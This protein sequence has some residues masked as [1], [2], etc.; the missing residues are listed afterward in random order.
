M[1]QTIFSA[2]TTDTAISLGSTLLT[3][4]I[5]F[6]LGVAIS[7]TYMKTG[8]KNTYSQ[9]FSITLVLVPT[10]IAI[11]ILMIGS[12][13][14]R[15][16]SLAGAFSIIRFRS[17]PG[18]PKDISYVLFAL[19][20]GLS[21]GVGFYQYAMLF[22]GVLCLLMFALSAFN[23]GAKNSCRKL[24]KI[25]IPEDMN[26]EGAFDDILKNFTTDYTLAKVK[27]TGLGS[28]YELVYNITMN[29]EMSQKEFLDA[30]RCRNGNLN[31]TLSMCADSAE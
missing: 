22:T 7:L 12:N 31:I 20:A 9:S 21:C 16:F 25:T 11:I 10:L 19:A 18:D 13:V 29:K 23:F 5:S 26:Y 4:A 17:S 27:T 1:F 14:A 3:I 6:I 15:A 28:L 2:A 8:S 30:L 24:L